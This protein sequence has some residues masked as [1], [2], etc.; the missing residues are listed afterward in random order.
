MRGKVGYLPCR[1]LFHTNSDRKGLRP[2]RLSCDSPPQQAVEPGARRGGQWWMTRGSRR[3]FRGRSVA[4]SIK[5]VDGV[6]RMVRKDD[7]GRTHAWTVA[8]GLRHGHGSSNER[9]V[10]FTPCGLRGHSLPKVH[11]A[12][13]W[14]REPVAAAEGRRVHA[15]SSS[16]SGAGSW[17]RFELH[18]HA[19]PPGRLLV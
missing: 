2:C 13:R 6:E 1:C 16:C 12:S 14:E 7:A 11:E 19:V 5:K 3:Q 15:H 8:S 4:F 17:H 10:F 18:Y 9:R